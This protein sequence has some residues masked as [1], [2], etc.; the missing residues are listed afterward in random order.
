MR[1]TLLPGVIDLL[2]GSD[3]RA[4]LLLGRGA[5][6]VGRG[7]GG[8]G[9]FSCLEFGD[10]LFLSCDEAVDLVVQC[11]LLRDVPATPM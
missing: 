3:V 11:S 4:E 1:L 6:L 8:E 9:C 5:G 2:E 10:Q 7:D